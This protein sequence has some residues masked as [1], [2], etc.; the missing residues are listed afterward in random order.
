MADADRLDHLAR[1]AM[2][3][4][5][6]KDRAARHLADCIT[7]HELAVGQH[8]VAAIARDAAVESEQYAI[9]HMRKAPGEEQRR[10]WMAH[11]AAQREQAQ[12]TLDYAAID[13]QDALDDLAKAR[14]LLLRCTVKHDRIGEMIRKARSAQLRLRDD[15]TSEEHAETA[16]LRRAAMPAIMAG[17]HAA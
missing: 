1:L 2:L 10:I 9:E 7:V 17:G 12:A 16:H 14:R 8:E 4:Q 13:V 11:E 15:R 5:R 6:R 3:S